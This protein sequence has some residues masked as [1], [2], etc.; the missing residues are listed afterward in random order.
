MLRVFASLF[1]CLFTYMSIFFLPVLPF[2]A[3][4]L[5]QDKLKL[6][7]YMCQ[8]LKTCSS[9]KMNTCESVGCLLK[10]KKKKR[11]YV[12]TQDTHSD[13]GTVKMKMIV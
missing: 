8:P 4:L 12:S 5:A 13:A 10:K 11:S 7:M 9:V 2:P 3:V 6:C 1:V